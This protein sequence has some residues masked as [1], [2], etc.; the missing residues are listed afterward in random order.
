MTATVETPTRVFLL[1]ALELAD[2]DPS[3]APEDAVAL[4]A[5]NFPQVA[6]ARLAAPEPRPDGT[7]GY[8]I[9]RETVKTKG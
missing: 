9:E 5:P 2:P 1:G 8:R 3:L 6:G 7:L 4:Y